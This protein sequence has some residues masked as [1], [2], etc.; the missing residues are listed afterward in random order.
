M[1]AVKEKISLFT[2]TRP[3]RAED[4]LQII[5]N[6]TKEKGFEY[7]GSGD[8]SDLAQQTEDDGLSMTGIVNDVIVGCGGIRKLWAGVGEVWLMLSPKVN[9]YPIR[10]YE[11]IKNGLEQLIEE[12]DFHRLQAWGRIGFTKAHTL[13]RHLKFKP[14][15]IAKCYTPDRCD[16]ILYSRIKQCTN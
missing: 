3:F 7:Y 6:G 4:M 10:T 1:E 12:N 13:F 15:G 5:G 11:C 16:C 9:L 2:G 14:E 8:L